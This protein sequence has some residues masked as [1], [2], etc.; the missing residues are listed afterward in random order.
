MQLEVPTWNWRVQS[1][2]KTLSSDLSLGWCIKPSFNHARFGYLRVV[3]NFFGKTLAI[4]KILCYKRSNFDKS[5]RW[6]LFLPKTAQFAHSNIDSVVNAIGGQ[7]SAECL[8]HAGKGR[9]WPPQKNPAAPGHES[10]DGHIRSREGGSDPS[11]VGVLM[12]AR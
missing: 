9:H 1:R 2:T 11:V 4:A 8:L 7:G 6:L 12:G 5:P 3:L 10:L